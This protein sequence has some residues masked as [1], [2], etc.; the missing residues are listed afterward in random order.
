MSRERRRVLTD[1]GDERM[2][3]A[4]QAG[5]L[6]ISNDLLFPGERAYPR[7]RSIVGGKLLLAL[8]G[9]AGL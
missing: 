7:Q 5:R 8:P 6:S 4:F 1:L 9:G 3:E 2:L